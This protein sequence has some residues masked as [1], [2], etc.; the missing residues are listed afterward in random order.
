VLR[1]PKSKIVKKWRLQ[2]GKMFL[3]D[4]EAGR[5][6]DD[7]ET[8]GRTGQRPSL[9]EWIS[10]IQVKLDEVDGPSPRKASARRCWIVSRPFGYNPGGSQVPDGAYGHQWRR[11]HRF[12]GQRFA[13]RG[14]SNKQQ[15]LYNYFKTV[16]CAGDEST[17]RPIRE[18]FG[19][20]TVSFIG[21][22]P[23]LLDLNNINPA[24]APRSVPARAGLQGHG[25]AC[26]TL[27]PTPTT[28]Q[29]LRAGHSA[30]GRLGQGRHRG[31]PPPP[32]CGRPK[33][34]WRSSYN[35]L[36]VSD[37]QR[38]MRRRGH[39]RPGLLPLPFTTIW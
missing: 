1:W 3:I 24:D 32:L 25:E 2:P 14:M 12:D 5:I 23:N 4:M 8:Q 34:P 20:S 11:S 37:P 30:P 13:A 17:D 9:P 16:V 6:I 28:S 39:P 21:R 22:K 27:A 33:M 7:K 26:A 10:R 36:I 18:A 29:I 38:S 19:M 15:A 31:A 35:I